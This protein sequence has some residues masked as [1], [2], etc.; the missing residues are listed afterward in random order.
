MARTTGAATEGVNSAPSPLGRTQ[1]IGPAARAQAG[2]AASPP[3]TSLP[4][5]QTAARPGQTQTAGPDVPAGEQDVPIS[6]P[7]PRRGAVVAESPRSIAPVT[8][9]SVK[10]EAEHRAFALDEFGPLGPAGA[11]TNAVEPAIDGPRSVVAGFAQAHVSAPGAS[12]AT[13]AS[14][15][16]ALDPLSSAANGAIAQDQFAEAVSTER[17]PQRAPQLPSSTDQRSRLAAEAESPSDS[18]EIGRAGADAADERTAAASRKSRSDV[19]LILSEVEGGLQVV[20]ASPEPGAAARERLRKVAD[21]VAAEFGRRVLA[22]SLNGAPI[23]NPQAIMGVT[24]GGH[25][26]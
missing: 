18:D 19:S 15:G 9:A 25:R 2:Q 24:H 1:I 10:Q 17:L 7:Q 16:P 6:T 13:P 8:L 11:A 21:E 14:A 5:G 20:A 26:S 12:G 22:L 23:E 4:D 3:P